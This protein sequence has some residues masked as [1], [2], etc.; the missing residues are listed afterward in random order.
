MMRT[1]TGAALAKYA[2]HAEAARR[3]VEYLVSPDGQKVY[4]EQNFEYPVVAGAAVE[5]NIAGLG[6]LKVDPLPI[7]RVAELRKDASLVV[8]EV[9]FDQ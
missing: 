2:P 4:A 9:G 3:L 7:A 6:A 8:D 5:P 1:V